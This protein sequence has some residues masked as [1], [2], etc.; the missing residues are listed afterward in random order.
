VSS[1]RKF[2]HSCH[3][4]DTGEGKASDNGKARVLGGCTPVLRIRARVGR[5]VPVRR[6]P[7]ATGIDT[8]D[9]GQ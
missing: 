4:E 6:H 5:G 9:V 1:R 7:S 3:R 8:S 2:S